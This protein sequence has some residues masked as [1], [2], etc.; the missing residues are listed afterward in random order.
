RLPRQCSCVRGGEHGWLLCPFS[1]LSRP[2]AASHAAATG[3][4]LLL[5]PRS[6]ACAGRV[7]LAVLLLRSWAY[8]FLPAIGLAGP[9]RVRALVLVRWPRTGMSR[10]CRNP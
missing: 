6:R 9:L 2:G 4:I 7:Q 1:I 3:P 8:F 10:R 5:S